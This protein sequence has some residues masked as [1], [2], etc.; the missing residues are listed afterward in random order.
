[1]VFAMAKVNMVEGS[2]LTLMTLKDVPLQR[3][4]Q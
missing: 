4:K 1:M 3:N 2:L